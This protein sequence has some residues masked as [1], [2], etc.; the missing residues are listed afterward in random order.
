MFME[1]FRK[2]T[3]KFN[4]QG[5]SIYFCE[6]AIVLS[7]SDPPNWDYLNQ[8]AI[9]LSFSYMPRFYNIISIKLHIKNKKSIIV[10]H[11]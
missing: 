6:D 5:Q 1:Y 4:F 10:E 9:D 11:E 7:Y 2:K 8:F 3:G